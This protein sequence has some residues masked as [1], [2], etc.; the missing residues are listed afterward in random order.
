MYAAANASL[1]VIQHLLAAGADKTLQDSTGLVALG[2]LQGRGPV[3]ANPVL[4]QTDRAAATQVLR[5]PSCNRADAPNPSTSPC[6]IR[7]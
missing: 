3:A 5:V 2:Y 7:R 1:P 4:N 6:Q